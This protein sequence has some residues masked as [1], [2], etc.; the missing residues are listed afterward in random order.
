MTSGM[1]WECRIITVF[2]GLVMVAWL[3]YRKSINEVR[4]QKVVRTVLT[5]ATVTLKVDCILKLSSVRVYTGWTL[6]PWQGIGTCRNESRQVDILLLISMLTSSL[7]CRC[8]QDIGLKHLLKKYSDYESAASEQFR[9]MERE[10][11]FR[12]WVDEKYTTDKIFIYT[13]KKTQQNKQNPPHPTPCLSWVLKWQST[14]SVMVLIK[15]VVVFS[16]ARRFL[17]LTESWRLNNQPQVI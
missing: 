13:G 7:L 10:Y 1:A 2:S 5:C 12:L 9:F 16:S 14:N 3:Y 15:S 17:R 4:Y 6:I 11:L 8:V